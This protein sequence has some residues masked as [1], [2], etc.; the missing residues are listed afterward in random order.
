MKPAQE[1]QSLHQAPAA[2]FVKRVSVEGL[3]V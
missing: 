2:N 3:N 1:Y